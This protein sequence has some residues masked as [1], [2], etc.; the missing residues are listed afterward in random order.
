MLGW[1]CDGEQMQCAQCAVMSY[2]I[3]HLTGS[4]RCICGKASLKCCLKKTL[5]NL[6]ALLTE[7]L[8]RNAVHAWRS[9]WDDRTSN[10]K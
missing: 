4:V 5:L 3:L 9:R 7:L 6:D 10:V 1:S 2:L 8:S